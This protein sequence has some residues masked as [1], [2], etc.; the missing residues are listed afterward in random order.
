MLRASALRDCQSILD[1][2]ELAQ[3]R[4]PRPVFH[5]LDGAAETERTAERNVAA[6]DDC[7]LL[8]R[9]L[10][11]VASVKTSARVL[12]QEMQWPV[13][14]SPTGASRLFHPDGEIAVARA[15]ADAGV[16]YGIS[17]GSTYS[18]EDVAAASDGPKM[19]QI[20]MQ[21]NRDATWELIERA[22]QAKYAA[23][24]LTVDVP[25][26]GKRERDLR[27]GF[28]MQFKWTPRS[29]LAFA[30]RP[31]WV[32]GQVRKGPIHLANYASPPKGLNPFVRPKY[33]GGQLDASLTWKDIRDISDRW[34]GRPFALKGVMAVDDACR[35]ADAGVTAIFVSNHGGRQLDGAA[36][37]MEAL[38]GIVR[39]VR[40]R[41]EV[42]L[43]GGIRRGVHM[44]KALASGAT[45][46]SI[47]RPYLYGLGAAG[48]AGVTRALDILRAELTLAM[49]LAGC[50]DVQHLDESWLWQP[51]QCGPGMPVRRS[52]ARA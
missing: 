49:R 24:C 7:K 28:S 29:L 46:C 8:A 31:A 10:V 5:F 41:I 44:V 1:L 25:A 27:E 45:A 2:R 34:G 47:G 26:V 6:F 16:L 43:D 32:L 51:A 13:I 37:A 3:R 38:P 52:K 39:A 36:A 20:Y 18:I 9:C 35:A 19:L 50:A 17:S 11:D 14:C 21:K 23:L 12:G 33:A 30:S 40:G 48:E 15:A 22:K 4:L 42:I